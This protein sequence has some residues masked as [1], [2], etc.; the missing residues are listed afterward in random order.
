MDAKRQIAAVVVLIT[1]LVMSGCGPGQ[2]LGPTVT[3][4]PTLTFTPTPTSTSTP[5][6]TPTLTPTI[7]PT[8][9]IGVPV[10]STGWEIT[11]ENAYA[12]DKL[13]S[14][15]GGLRT[16]T[17]TPKNINTVFLVVEC[18]FKSK[19]PSQAKEGTVNNLGTLAGEDFL[20][21]GEVTTENGKVIPSVIFGNEMMGFFT[22]DEGT[23]I[24]LSA[25][26]GETS[27]LVFVIPKE[28]INELYKLQFI[29][30]PDV[31]FQVKVQP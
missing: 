13:T 1:S 19:D 26:D 29:S 16:T 24:K 20:L 11:I 5:T 4:T 8:P 6:S 23:Y 2:L 30:F 15:V 7:T 18:I 17:W 31:I 12:K 22:L 28:S 25:V 10:I 27:S 14:S 21:Y 9:G 3:P